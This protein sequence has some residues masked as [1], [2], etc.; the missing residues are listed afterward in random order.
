MTPTRTL[1][2]LSGGIDSV[3]LAHACAAEGK[4]LSAIAFDYGQRHRKELGYA[5]RAARKLGIELVV[6]D[7]RGYSRLMRG[8]SLTD[9]EVT[10][11][12][13]HYTRTGSVNVVPNRN[14]VFMTV[15]YAHAVLAGAREMCLGFLSEDAATAPDTSPEFLAAF[16]AMEARA[17]EGLADPPPRVTAPLI[18]LRK[19]DVLRMGAG[20]GVDWHDTWTCF[21]GGELHCGTCASCHDRRHAFTE[22]ELTD[23]TRYEK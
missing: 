15:A 17:V 23:P 14:P 1:V 3:V 4:E 7:L 9:A 2:V 8:F 16:N 12:D 11:P 22:A 19:A 10:V 13:E 20:L 21:K 6:A 18:T 5:E